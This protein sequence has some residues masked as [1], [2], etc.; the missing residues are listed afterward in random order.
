MKESPQR[1]YDPAPS[2]LFL[3]ILRISS[4]PVTFNFPKKRFFSFL[5]TKKHHKY[6]PFFQML[7]SFPPTFLPVK[8]F[9]QKSV[10]VSF[11]ILHLKTKQTLRPDSNSLLPQPSLKLI[12]NPFEVCPI[13]ANTVN[14]GIRHSALWKTVILISGDSLRQK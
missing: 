11:T 9:L 5:K 8:E 14:A 1:N 10:T 7:L 3:I 2:L 6:S 13:S 12:R 4:E